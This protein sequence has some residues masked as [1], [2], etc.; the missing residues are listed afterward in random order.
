AFIL[1][2]LQ[3]MRVKV[4]KQFAQL[5]PPF[6]SR[7]L[8]LI[9]SQQQ[10]QIVAQPSINRVLEVNLQYVSR[11]LAFRSATLEWVLLAGKRAAGGGGAP[12]C[13]LRQKAG[14]GE[15]RKRRE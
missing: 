11:D 3:H 15:G 14:G 5:L 7:H 2:I 12:S 10:S 6:P 13:R 4:G 8:S 9:R 1:H